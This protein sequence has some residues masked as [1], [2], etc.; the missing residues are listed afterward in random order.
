M[1]TQGYVKLHRTV[2]AWEWLKDANVYKFFTLL[3]AAANYK[4]GRFQGRT[5]KPGQLVT[6][7]RKLSILFEMNER[8]VMRCMKCLEETGEITVER[9]ANYTLI[10]V[11]NYDKFQ[12]SVVSSVVL[13]TTQH[14]TQYTTQHT[15]QHTDNQR[16]EERKEIKN[17]LAHSVRVSEFSPPSLSDVEAYADEKRASR[18]LALEFYEFYESNGWKIGKNDMRN[19]KMAFNGWIRRHK[20]DIDDAPKTKMN[21]L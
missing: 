19:W 18:R 14:T 2:F 13:D 9:N 4:E 17:S 6:S 12:S 5:I 20:D 21:I 1:N 16:K 15:T 10:T 11:N 3:C 7:V 8:T